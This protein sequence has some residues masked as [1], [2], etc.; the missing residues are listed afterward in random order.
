MMLLSRAFLR[1]L[2]LM[3]LLTL[4]CIA[5]TLTAREIHAMALAQPDFSLRP[6]LSDPQSQGQVSHGYYVFDAH[7]GAV[8]KDA[9]E[10]QNVGS[11]SGKLQLYASDATTAANG[12]SAFHESA[13][14]NKGS[15]SWITLDKSQ[16]ELK[17]GEK[18][19]IS[20]TI[21]IPNTSSPGQHLAGIVGSNTVQENLPT[22]QR[23]QGN[24][25]ASHVNVRTLHVI[26]VQ[27]NLPGAR[28]EKLTASGITAGGANQ[29]QT[30]SI[31]LQNAGNAL[32]S[33][34]GTLQ[35]FNDQGSRV[36]NIPVKI[37]TIVPGTEIAYPALVQKQALAPGNYRAALDLT[38]GDNQRLH[39]E[40]SI[41]VT[42][43]Q[44]NKVFTGPASS[45]L[46]TAP[47]GLNQ[48]SPLQWLIGGL[49][50]LLAGSGVFV[51]CRKLFLLV[52]VHHK[53]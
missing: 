41:T 44:V 51:W 36:Q 47:S 23:V 26:P 17:A 5:G 38:Y 14:Q 3:A 49:L 43:E 12:G 35:V 27:I 13:D 52:N 46:L 10:I 9:V 25:A 34:Q 24:N 16:I 22:P 39:Y 37:S 1:F 4:F 28:V 32:I 18:T 11:A 40:N 53:S 7:P 29:M 19:T 30:L 33:A 21:A 8:L 45:P 42:Q 6:V 2:L 48:I 31:G 50:V 20:F 15:G